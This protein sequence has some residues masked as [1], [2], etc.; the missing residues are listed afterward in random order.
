MEQEYDAMVGDTTIILNRSLL[1]DF[2][3]PYTES[4][5]QMV[6]PLREKWRMSLWVF[7]KPIE[8]ILWGAM[9]AVFLSTG[10]VIWLTERRDST[11]FGGNNAGKQFVNI[12]YFS[13]QALLSVPKGEL[14]RT[15]KR[16]SLIILFYGYLETNRQLLLK[17]LQ[18]FMK[19]KCNVNKNKELYCR[20]LD[21]Q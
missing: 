13:F 19:K 10:L 5:V 16:M 7:L 1:V 21:I 2:T 3:L 6:V 20:M 17:K 9:L 18:K 11:Y 15:N 14:N 4:G 8:S 12:A